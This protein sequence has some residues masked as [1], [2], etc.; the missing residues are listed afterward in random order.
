[1]TIVVLGGTGYLG[2]KILHEAVRQGMQSFCFYRSEQAKERVADQEPKVKFVRLDEESLEDF[3]GA[4]QVDWVVNT[5]C[6]YIGG[7]QDES[8]VIESNLLAPLNVL[9]MAVKYRVPRFISAGTGLPDEF[10]MYTFAKKQL[11][12]F[13]RY[14]AEKNRIQFIN[15]ELE[16]FYAADEPQTRFLHYVI[17]QLRDNAPVR[18]TKGTQKRDFIYIDDVLG[19]FFQILRSP[20]EERYLDIPVGTGEGPTIRDLITYLAEQ[21]GSCSQLCF[22]AVPMRQNE[23]DSIADPRLLTQLGYTAQYSWKNGMKKLLEEGK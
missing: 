3:F 12:E 13:G 20:P 11:N 17:K 1:M 5:C 21:T 2:G 18:V 19:A 10:N 6:S 8:R 9:E 23:P 15:M 22:G 14:Y 16:N 7:E 4:Q